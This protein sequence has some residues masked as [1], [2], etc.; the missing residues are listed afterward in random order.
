MILRT[1]ATKTKKCE[2][3][4]VYKINSVTVHPAG[5]YIFKVNNRYTRRS[6]KYVQS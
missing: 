1:P 4:E 5:M 6:V 2:L 3:R